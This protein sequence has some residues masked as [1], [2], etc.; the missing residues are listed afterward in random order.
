[1]Y[2][3]IVGAGRVGV[4]LA[5]WLLAAD[6]EVA[7]IERDAARCAALENELGSISVA[8]DG[9][10]ADILARA[11]ANRADVFI[12]ATGRDDDNM[13]ACQLARHRFGASRIVA[14]VN[15]GGDMVEA[16]IRAVDPDVPFR[17]VHATRGKALRAEP[18]A[19]LYERGRVHHVRH[20]EELETQLCSWTPIN[21]KKSPD[22]LDALVWAV[23]DLVLGEREAGPLKGYL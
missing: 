21:S 18:V 10:E 1:M 8:G 4:S 12:A 19:A 9:T 16:T 13:V 14:E 5:R 2:V 15:N 7:V 22:R 11:G 17:K 20:L 23:T 6:H 3:L